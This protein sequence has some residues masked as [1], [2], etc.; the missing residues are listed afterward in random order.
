[1]TEDELIQ[2]DYDILED[3]NYL[4]SPDQIEQYF[5]DNGRDYFDCGQGYFQ[6]EATIFVK[7]GDDFF[8]VTIT[9]DC[10]GDWQEY[11]DKV[12]HIEKITNVTWEKIDKPISYS[13]KPVKL[14]MNLTT[15]Q[16]EEL[17]N[18]L[19]RRRIDYTFDNV[20]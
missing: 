18:W 19:H 6:D 3:S 10:I 16:L 4:T 17:Y 12:Y 15:N 8:D 9:A 7:I 5:T 2:L 11:G 14:I 20:V 13:R 1:M